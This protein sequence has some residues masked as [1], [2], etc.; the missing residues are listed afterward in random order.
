MQPPNEDAAQPS[1]AAQPAAGASSDVD[2]VVVGC[3]FAG[4]CMGVRLKQVGQ[5]SFTIIEKGGDVGGTWRDNHYPGCACDVPSHL[6]S[7]S[8][9]SKADWTRLYP[10][11]P[12]LYSYLRDV[13]E[14]YGLRPHIRFD[15]AMLQAEWSERDFLWRVT[16]TTTGEVI[17]ARVM[18][19]G[20]GALHIPAYP[21]VPGVNKFQ[22]TAFHSANWQAN[23][24]LRGKR[25]AVIGAGASA[26]QFVPKLAAQAEK[27]HV[28]Q[29]TAPWVFPKRDRLIGKWER[30]LLRHLPGYRQAFR[31]WLH[32]R[33]ESRMVAFSNDWI[34]RIFEGRA[35][36]YIAR[37][38]ADP[39][40][41]KAVTPDY[42]MG[43]KRIL[44]S[45]DYYPALA[46]P[47]VEVVT[48]RI[49]ALLPRAI[50]TADG[51]E[52]PIDA[53][54]YGTGF[55]FV[56]SL[57]NLPVTGR[58]G[59]ALHAAWRQAIRSYHGIT[60][61]GFPN[62]FMLMGPNTFLGHNSVIMMIE[63]QADYVIDCL[64][65]M[66]NRGLRVI[67]VRAD[68]QLRFDQWLQSHLTGSIWQSGGCRSWYQDGA[69]RN[70]ALWPG[71]IS[72]YR[73]GIRR[74]SLSDYN[75]A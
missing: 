4:L 7:L 3:G 18:V 39:G 48:D 37:H 72:R 12:E 68:S 61:S 64:K 43:C 8:F 34:L 29:R 2:V 63:A 66:R 20:V 56:D 21:E 53:L 60:V 9:A 17:T 44:L 70:V 36:R 62:F 13:A 33:H 45:D 40:L 10:S 15:T 55:D 73:Q 23:C 49:A 31:Q 71:F 6:Y 47:N 1:N 58:N 25:V 41:R 16:T 59:I 19:S 50:V 46:Q 67:D 26:I 42:R 54:I 51:S 38:V 11:Q 24:D 30:V 65:Q 69:G 32:W 28:F 5:Y 22:G 35:R 74:M 57:R 27:V 75:V 52:R 14:R